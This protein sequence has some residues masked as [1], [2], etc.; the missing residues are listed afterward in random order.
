MGKHDTLD[1]LPVEEAHS[2]TAAGWT[3]QIL[4]AGLFFS[5][6]YNY[7]STAQFSVDPRRVR[8]LLAS[9]TVCVLAQSV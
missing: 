2:S 4:F 1:R 6:T 7:C 8:Y 5:M 3:S 9:V